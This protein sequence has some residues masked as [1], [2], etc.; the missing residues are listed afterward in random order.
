MKTF[1]YLA[2]ISILAGLPQAAQAQMA[3]PDCAELSG[4]SPRASVDETHL[5]F[6]IA[7]S[8]NQQIALAMSPHDACLASSVALKGSSAVSRA[9][10]DANSG[11][12]SDTAAGKLTLNKFGATP[13]NIGIKQSDGSTLYTGRVLMKSPT[14]HYDFTMSVS[15]TGW[16]TR[17]CVAE[18][19][20]E[21]GQS[22]LWNGR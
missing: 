10:Y 6:E 20:T 15:S 11:S 3:E 18:V 21:T 1:T 19:L 22:A 12:C 5:K 4:G 17:A 16:I 9:A 8:A 2:V 7:V 14:P 13:T